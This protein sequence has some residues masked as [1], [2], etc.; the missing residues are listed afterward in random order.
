V[1]PAHRGIDLTTFALTT[2]TGILYLSIP[3]DDAKVSPETIL[4]PYLNAILTLTKGDQSTGPVFSLFYTQ[5]DHLSPSTRDDK[6]FVP[7]ITRLISECADSAAV[8]AEEIFQ[9]TVRTL[10]DLR[11]KRGT[12]VLD[13]PIPFWPPMEDEGGNDDDW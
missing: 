8:V 13:E 5:L 2:Y 1:R 10:D 4:Q 6:L 9:D 3:L 11:R 7:G 12:E